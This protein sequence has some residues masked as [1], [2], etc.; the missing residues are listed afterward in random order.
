M[1]IRSLSGPE[2]DAA[3]AA[4]HRVDLSAIPGL[5]RGNG[6][7]WDF[8]GDMDG[9][10]RVGDRVYA[11]AATDFDVI[12]TLRTDAVDRVAES[13]P[14]RERFATEL[15]TDVQ[16]IVTHGLAEAVAANAAQAAAARLPRMAA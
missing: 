13:D 3:I 5:A 16:Q 8:A 9:G 11:G 10:Y 14:W 12:G 15:P 4:A 7:G 2:Q 1:D 6:E